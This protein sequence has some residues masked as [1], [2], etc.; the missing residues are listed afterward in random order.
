MPSTDETFVGRGMARQKDSL[1]VSDMGWRPKDRSLYV[2]NTDLYSAQGAQ[3]SYNA[4]RANSIASALPRS[5][6]LACIETD[7]T[8]MH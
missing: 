2:P 7:V 6:P 1:N 5:R 3:R 8:E 4:L